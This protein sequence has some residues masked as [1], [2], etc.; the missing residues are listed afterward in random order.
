MLNRTH[1]Q[2]L[3]AHVEATHKSGRP[4][5]SNRDWRA[6]TPAWLSAKKNREQVLRLLGRL[7]ERLAE[8]A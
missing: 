7:K 8:A 6:R 2:A 1:L 3:S 4:T 5:D